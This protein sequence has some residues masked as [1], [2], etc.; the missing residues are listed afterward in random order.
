MK[1]IILAKSNLRKNKGL[2]I[3]ISLLILIS[4]MFICVSGLLVFDY[5]KNSQK[6]AKELNTTQAQI[7]SQGDSDIID[8]NYIDS[9]IPDTVLVSQQPR[10]TQSLNGCWSRYIHRH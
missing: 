4:S 2:S 8:K 7:Y 1:S 10:H 5:N 9:I 6:V 3:C